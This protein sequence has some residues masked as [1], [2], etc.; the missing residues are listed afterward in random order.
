MLSAVA[1]VPWV[2]GACAFGKKPP[3][4][5]GAA[6]PGAVPVAVPAPVLPTVLELTLV[7]APALNP[8]ASQ[9]PSPLL[10]RL[11]ELRSVASFAKG[12][13]MALYQGDQALLAGDLVLREQYT[14]LPGERQV[15]RRVLANET[16]H[17]GFF[18]AYR[19]LERSV[20]RV[21]VEIKPGQL[22]R[23]ELRADALALSFFNPS[24]STRADVSTPPR[25]LVAGPV[26]ATPPLPAAN[27]LF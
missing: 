1:A 23:L 25:D 15:V 18:A 11:Y 21:Q 24:G 8:S 14:L 3:L 22:N 27:A 17:L 20:W 4:P 19:D 5:P 26:P 2:L 7:A 9:R 10:L 6:A 13:F 12:D 16:R